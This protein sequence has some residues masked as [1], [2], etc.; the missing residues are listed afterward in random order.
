[1][2]YAEAAT[3]AGIEVKAKLS[4]KY[5]ITNL[6]PA[7]QFLGIE[8]QR[9][10]TGISIGQKTYITRILRWFGM[11][12]THGVS[13]PM[14]PNSKLEMAKNWGEKKLEQEDITDYQAVVGSRMYAAL[15]TRPDISYAVAALSRYKPRPFT[16]NMTSGKRVLLYPK[17][18]A[19]FRLHFSGNGIGIGIGNCL[20]GY[21][22]SHWANDSADHK[23][24]GGH[25][26]LA[27]N[28]AV[29]WQSRKQSLI[30]MSTLEAVFIGCS[31]A[32]REAKCS[33]QLQKDIRGSQRDSQPLPNNCDNQ[34]ART[35]ITSGIIK[36]RSK[37]ID[38]CYH[39]SRILHKHRIVNYSYVHTDENMADKLTKALTKDKH[40]KFTKAMG[41]W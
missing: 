15:A 2:S 32:S 25:V 38:V 29:S 26:F 34:G 19:D 1:M 27:S 35:L 14:D 20:I 4:E 40:T 8:I 10:D 33:L 5:K 16:G 13:M 12:H 7:S 30:A 37:H 36:A 31:E 41:L 6:G 11:E 39:N 24:Q 22:D 3:K 28:W 17:S 18:T 23:S 21:S 9:D